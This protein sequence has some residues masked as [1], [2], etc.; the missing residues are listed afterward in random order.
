MVDILKITRYHY[1]VSKL[2][3]KGEFMKNNICVCF[4]EDEKSNSFYPLTLTRPVHELVCGTR[5]IKQRVLDILKPKKENVFHIIREELQS[6]YGVKNK[7]GIPDSD[8]LFINSRL[9]L[10]DF[11]KEI[12]FDKEC[13]YTVNGET[14][15]FFLKKKILKKESYSGFSFLFE[16]VVNVLEQKHVDGIMVNYLWELVD[17]M[18]DLTAYDFNNF[19]E[20][21]IHGDFSVA[22]VIHGDSNLVYC[23]ENSNVHAFVEL[24]TMNG[25][26]IIEQGAEIHSFTRIEGPSYIGRN[27]IVLGA[28][29]RSGSYIG[30]NCRAG[31]EVENSIMLANSN[32]YHEGF[33]G[34]SYV[35]EWVNLGALTTNSDLKNNYETVDV[36]LDGVKTDTG[37]IKAGCYIG[38]HSK[39]SIGCLLNTGTY[40]GAMCNLLASGG[41]LPKYL[42][43]FSNYA[44]DRFLKSFPL[45][46][47]FETAS[48]VK[49]RRGNVFTDEE[50]TLFED[51]FNRTKAKRD[52]LRGRS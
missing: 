32:K 17:L 16:E 18:P 5:S 1:S 24:D 4:Y 39:T 14:A 10:P 40:I 37:T 22:S 21:N 9:L 46:S 41:L 36:M 50:K 31:G 13:V 25:P 28:K 48:T 29:I 26:V 7:I 38:D 19:Y 27:A 20:S 43:S 44:K 2:C 15:A 12:K 35:G 30:E 45:K 52:K 8:T 42:P 34:H 49:Q 11:L 33:L 3:L 47:L 6:V 23:A 51:I